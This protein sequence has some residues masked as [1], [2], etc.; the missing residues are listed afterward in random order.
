M[1]RLP[2]LRW[3]VS[4]PWWLLISFCPSWSLPVQW[5]CLGIPCGGHWIHIL[6][7]WWI[8]QVHVD[9][10]VLVG[11][12]HDEEWHHPWCGFQGHPCRSSAI[13]LLA[14]Q[15]RCGSCYNFFP[16]LYLFP[17]FS[18]MTSLLLLCSFLWGDW[19]IPTCL[20][21]IFFPSHVSP[22][23]SPCSTG[24]SHSLVTSLVV[25][26]FPLPSIK[27]YDLPLR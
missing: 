22:L 2:W 9:I 24:L 12:V 10:E 19:P 5:S 15:W 25:T 1:T 11:C 3:G 7:A 17:H 8:V 13:S 18:S 14:Y 27:F 16:F 6:R 4:I 20:S 21:W 26:T 23:V